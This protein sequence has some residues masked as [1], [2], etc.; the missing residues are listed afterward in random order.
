[1]IDTP[2]QY[3]RIQTTLAFLQPIVANLNATIERHPVP[4]QGSMEKKQVWVVGR[5]RIAGPRACNRHVTTFVAVCR[6]KMA[7]S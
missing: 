1:M 7:R 2:V 4:R 6:A 3:D 5:K